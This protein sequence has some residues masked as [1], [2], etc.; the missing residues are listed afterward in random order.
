MYII[1]N[2]RQIERIKDMVTVRKNMD[3]YEVFYHD[4]STGELWKSFFPRGYKK[5]QGPKLLRPEPLPD[6][7]ELQLEICL[8]SPDDSDAIGLGIE[9]SVKPEKWEE[10]IEILDKNRKKYLRSHLN[11]FIKHLGILSPIE[12]LK[13]IELHPEDLKIDEEKFTA[14]KKRAK[15]IKL[16]RFFRI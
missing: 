5:H 12:S 10:I 16:K 14:L 7:L 4:P 1:N 8:N 9:C 13:E 11:T 6:N 3:T 15:R 2:K